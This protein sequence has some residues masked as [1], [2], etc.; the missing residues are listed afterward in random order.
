MHVVVPNTD[1]EA[2]DDE[3]FLR[4]LDGSIEAVRGLGVPFLLIGEIASSVFGRDR[5]TADIDLF[6]R[7]EHAPRILEALGH[8]G[9]ET[10]VEFE[11]WLYKATIDDVDVDVIFRASRDILID[12]DMLARGRSMVFRG[13]ELPMAPPEDM[14]VM[15]AVAAGEDTARY[16]YDALA[17]LAR[18]DLDWDYLLTRARQHGARRMLSLLLFGASLDLLV[19][20][21]AIDSLFSSLKG[22]VPA[23]A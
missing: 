11:H 10:S 13:R 8:R 3:R 5:G 17:I 1:A 21:P 22:Q 9:F 14:I 18:A 2:H 19:P 20:D 23:D 6:V 7:P 16:W 15:K 12:D 4:V